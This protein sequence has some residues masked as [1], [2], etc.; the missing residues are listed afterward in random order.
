MNATVLPAFSVRIL[1]PGT[2]GL[3]TFQESNIPARSRFYCLEPQAMGSLWQESFTSYLNRLG[4]T[5]HVSP[6][7]M[8]MQEVIPL[9]DKG[10]E[11]SRHWLGALS[12][13]Y[14]MSMNGAGLT[15]LEW[16]EIFEKLTMRSDLHLL[17]LRWWIG[18]LSSLGHLHPHPV[19]CP[20]C[21]SE[22]QAQELCI[23]QPLLWFFKV[24]TTCPRHHKPL[25]SHCPHCQK[26]QSV[27]ALQTRP[28]HC[29]KCNQWLGISSHKESS[30]KMEDDPMQ[31]ER[32]VLQAL[33]E[34]RTASTTNGGI[35]WETFF[36]QLAAGLASAASLV[37][38]KQIERLTGVKQFTF[39]QWFEQRW[40]PS[41]ETILQLC[42]VCEVTPLQIMKGEISPLIEV[43]TRNTPSRPPVHRRAKSK[44][45]PE[46][47]L[48]LIHA[49]LDGREKPLS[50]A[51]LCKRLGYGHR[52]L[53]YLFPEECAL[54]VKLARE[55]KK[56]RRAQQTLPTCE[57]VR[58]AVF[59]LH[60]Q[61]IYP[62]VHKVQSL[63]I[64]GSMR[65]PEARETWHATLQELGLET[66][67]K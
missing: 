8:I 14:A 67:G 12:A 17:T 34:L 54:I 2:Q 51:Q 6:R 22:W 37:G 65:L 27:I 29:T 44:V 63:L 43:I 60:E 42:Y 46:R 62:S 36:T 39:H 48:E 61:G 11:I 57:R 30:H 50:L 21:Y 13:A 25:A 33:E 66:R 20:M 53:K 40:M 59:S 5:H 58:Q 49:V 26:T 15:A 55:D 31:W 24:I 7:A 47:S 45:D 38:W 64:G 3:E 32:W 10:Q 28:G 23:Y 56:Q 16:T 19:W 35:N 18:N 4:W 1:S 9:L 41:L 52:T